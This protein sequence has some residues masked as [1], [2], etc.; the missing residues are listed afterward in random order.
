M[1]VGLLVMR[2]CRLKKTCGWTDEQRQVAIEP[3]TVEETV[4][5]DVICLRSFI[6]SVLSF[7]LVS[8][9]GNLSFKNKNYQTN[10]TGG[11][12]WLVVQLM[13]LACKIEQSKK[14]LFQLLPVKLT[15]GRIF[16]S[17][18]FFLDLFVSLEL[19]TPCCHFKCMFW[20]LSCALC[21]C[22]KCERSN[23]FT[24]NKM[25]PRV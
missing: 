8:P 12:D 7:C 1:V 14:A 3:G 5:S 20:Y 13:V 22:H 21:K 6:E 16:E 15:S 4:V 17:R 2:D 19:F 23:W 11:D 25:F 24:A 10:Q 9:F 18:W